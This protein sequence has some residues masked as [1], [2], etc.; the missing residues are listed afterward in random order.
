MLDP[1]SVFSIASM[2]AL[3]CW[4]ALAVSLFIA[5]VR[6]WIW[7]IAGLAIPALIAIA[8]A[9]L[10]GASWGA[11]PGGGFGSIGEVRA[12]FTND[13]AL[14]AGWLH[15]L[16]FDLFVGTWIVRTAVAEGIWRILV[17]PC[18]FL[19]LMFGPV[20]LLLFLILRY[21]FARSWKAALA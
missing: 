13:S 21:A 7:T 16:A 17:I 1:A 12:L 5:P 8:Y 11:T 10:I 15:Y 4:I 14:A 18:L 2:I 20:G 9:L 6:A 19:T 3:P